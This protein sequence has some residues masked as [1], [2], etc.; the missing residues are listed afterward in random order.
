MW[1]QMGILFW[2]VMKSGK[3]I[4]HIVN[5]FSQISVQIKFL[6]SLNSFLKKWRHLREGFFPFI[7]RND[8]KYLN[9]EKYLTR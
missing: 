6:L 2:V 7:L 9:M 5:C 8:F 3:I 1:L 4:G